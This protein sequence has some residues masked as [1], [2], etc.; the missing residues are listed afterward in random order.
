MEVKLRSL[1]GFRGERLTCVAM[2]YSSMRGSLVKWNCSGS[3]V[4]S[5]TWRPRAR[6]SGSGD[7]AD[8]VKEFYIITVNLLSQTT[9]PHKGDNCL[10]GVLGE[11]N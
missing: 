7:L 8:K 6:Y 1:D 11:S 5:D 3:S 9:W 10:G 4:D 2:E